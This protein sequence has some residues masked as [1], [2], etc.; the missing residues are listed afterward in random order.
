MPEFAYGSDPPKAVPPMKPEQIAEGVTLI[1]PLSRKGVGPGM[2]L[3]VPNQDSETPIEIENGIPSLRMKWAEEGYCVVE[4]R[5]QASSSAL[6]AAVTK[7]DA[8]Q[9]CEPK[10]KMGLVCTC[11][12]H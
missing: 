8:C 5:P 10:E 9:E 12:V 11:Q 6:K 4:I 3:L 2:I 1:R 7:L